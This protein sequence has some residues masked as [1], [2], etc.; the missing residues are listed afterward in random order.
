MITLIG[1]LATLLLTFFLGIQSKNV[2]QSEYV[3]AALTSI[4]ISL[5]NYAFIKIT[6]SGSIIDVVV[7]AIGG[8][9]GIVLS[10]YI[11]DNHISKEKKLKEQ[12]KKFVSR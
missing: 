6:I 5:C 4:G 8:S 3:L 1:F 10:I 11:H 9:V 12:R 7:M 2:N